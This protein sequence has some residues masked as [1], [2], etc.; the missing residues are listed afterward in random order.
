ME[1]GL[2]ITRCGYKDGKLFETSARIEESVYKRNGNPSME[3]LYGNFN[4]VKGLENITWIFWET[5]VI[6][7]DSVMNA[8]ELG[9]RIDKYFK[10]DGREYRKTE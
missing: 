7:K 2:T 10:Q 5:Y 3:F 1:K 4:Q 8:K 6:D 9:E